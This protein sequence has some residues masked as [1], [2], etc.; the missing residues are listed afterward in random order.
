MNGV[1]S[2]L[3]IVIVGGVAGGA[4]A[5]AR[6]R[7][8]NSNAEITILE[9]GPAVSFAN[10]GLPY[11]VGGEIFDRDK[12]LVATPQLFWERFRV[13]VRTEHEVIAIDR[14]QQVVSG[15]TSAGDSFS[16]PYD[17]LILATGSEP[18][19]PPFCQIQAENVF[20]LWTLADMDRILAYMKKRP[21]K[22]GTVVGGGYVGLEVVEQ[23]AR[24]GLDVTLVER[25]PQVMP[26][27]DLE[28]AR[29]VE[30]EL[31]VQGVRV[32]LSADVQNLLCSNQR[33][34]AVK[35]ADG[36]SITTDLVIAAV[37]VKP[38]TELALSAGLEIGTA[39]G[40]R[41][42]E[43]CQTNDANIYAVGDIVEYKHG[44]LD[45][46]MRVPLAG[47][48]NRS[49]RV[50]GAHAACGQTSPLSAV[51]GTSIVRVFDVTAGTAGLGLKA[52]DAAGMAARTAII[53][54]P[55]HASYFPGARNMTVKLLYRPESGQ[56][57]G[58]QIVGAEGVDKRLDVVSTLLH[59]RGT[60]HDL[61]GLDLAYAPPYSSAKDPLH[62]AAFVAQ[63]DLMEKP[64]LIP[65]DAQLDDCQ[66][67]DV[68]T[69]S[70]IEQLPLEGAIHMPIDEITERWQ[71]L[72]ANR[73]TVAVCHSGKRAHVAAC[74]LKGKGFKSVVNLNGGMSI[75]QLK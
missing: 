41:I 74:W 61:A 53:Q 3:K 51:Q 70:E 37:G 33:V 42:N 15:K 34:T 71:E 19:R 30:M 47:P 10:C 26:P 39:G 48:A 62:M 4:S 11:H 57:L 66:V 20:Q 18:L 32:E 75:R 35:L 73:P 29:L 43:Y 6:A 12:L 65:S 27:L 14:D 1:G 46:A 40:V 72:D 45:R 60:V 7:R 31:R 36:G 23:L 69:S 55:H 49:G 59:F 24:R 2:G 67:V 17:K 52:C 28:M 58:V 38:R 64:S 22:K 50:A 21:C 16:L 5:A 25:L 13:S 9:K 54:A 63:N 68:R 56:V 8:C 44:T